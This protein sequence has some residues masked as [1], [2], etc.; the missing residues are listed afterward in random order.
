MCTM[1]TRKKIMDEEERKKLAPAEVEIRIESDSVHLEIPDEQPGTS[2]PNMKK[3]LSMSSLRA[4]LR[5][6]RAKFRSKGGTEVRAL[7]LSAALKQ[8]PAGQRHGGKP[9][10]HDFSLPRE[11]Q[12]TTRVP[13]L[14][15][16]LLS[17]IVCSSLYITSCYKN[18]QI[19]D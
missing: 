6:Q 3:T 9:I 18:S 8:G 17:T 14:R 19:L 4:K 16:R 10:S 12:Q 15:S 13:A 11:V 7:W 2:S 1:K 5:D